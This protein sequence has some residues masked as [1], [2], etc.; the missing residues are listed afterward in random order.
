[1]ANMFIDYNRV[2]HTFK[3][4]LRDASDFVQKDTYA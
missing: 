4:L 1:M 3:D 2:R